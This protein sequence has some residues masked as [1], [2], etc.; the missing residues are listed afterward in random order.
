MAEY[1][2]PKME[3]VIYKTED[4]L[5]GSDNAEI[6]NPGQLRPKSEQ[7]PENDLQ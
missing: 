1:K 2:A 7:F 5:T 4:V 3:T 6:D